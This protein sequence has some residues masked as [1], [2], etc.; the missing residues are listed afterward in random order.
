MQQYSSIILMLVIVAAFYILLIRPQQ[1]QAKRQRELVASLASGMEIVTIG[2]IFATVVSLTDDR[3]R[4]SLADGSELE[5]AKH[6]VNSVVL[7]ESGDEAIDA[8]DPDIL[9]DAS[10]D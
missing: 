9:G 8:E 5:I 3:L 2:G 7:P 6:A 10:N 4:V 1:T